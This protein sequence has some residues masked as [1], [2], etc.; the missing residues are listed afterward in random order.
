MSMAATCLQSR[1]RNAEGTAREL[2]GY[3]TGKALELWFVG[4]PS[5]RR[6]VVIAGNEPCREI[7]PLSSATPATSS[8][9]SGDVAIR[10][11][12]SPCESRI[13]RQ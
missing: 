11:F 5:K 1:E 3:I 9:A 2:K 8:A 12:L 7:C 10:H 6:A 13:Q 4:E